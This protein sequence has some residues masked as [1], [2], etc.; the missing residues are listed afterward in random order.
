MSEFLTPVQSALFTRLTDQISSVNIYDDVPDMTDGK[1][2]DISPYIVVGD[3]NDIPWDTDDTL[4]STVLATIHIFSIYQGKAEAK[5]IMGQIYQA[6]HRQSS[7]LI[8]AGYRFVDCLSD[9]SEIFDEDDGAT[10]HGVCRYR[11][12]IEKE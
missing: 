9:F 11:L 2:E 7:N 8:A 6:L 4:G 12:T 10:R 1:P 5:T 3:D